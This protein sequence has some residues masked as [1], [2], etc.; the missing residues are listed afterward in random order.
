M[1][2][3]SLAVNRS[4]YV[5]GVEKIALVTGLLI[6]LKVTRPGPLNW[7]QNV[8]H[9]CARR[10][11]V[12]G[13]RAVQA[14]SVRQRDCLVWSG[15]DDRRRVCRQHRD[16]SLRRWPSVL[17]HWPSSAARKCPATVKLASVTVSSAS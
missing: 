4:T 6:S 15:V 17:S 2:C 9:C 3:V 16:A 10:E 11:A 14:G 1:R 5:P 12:V 13:D 7:L 8:D